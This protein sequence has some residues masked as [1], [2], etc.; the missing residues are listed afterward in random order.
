MN[1]TQSCHLGGQTENGSDE[2]EVSE[3][4]EL[5]E[6]MRRRL[7]FRSEWMTVRHHIGSYS[8]LTAYYKVEESAS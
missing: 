8:A 5:S 1:R 4:V 3:K 6:Y 7:Y 2:D